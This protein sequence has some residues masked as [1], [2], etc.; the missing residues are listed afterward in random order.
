M[1]LATVVPQGII[2][3]AL[4]ALFVFG[5]IHGRRHGQEIADRQVLRDPS[6]TR[7]TWA[8]DTAVRSTLGV[9]LGSALILLSAIQLITRQCLYIFCIGEARSVGNGAI[10]YAIFGILG[11]LTLLSVVKAWPSVLSALRRKGSR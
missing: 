4:G 2:G 10:A 3:L 7:E 6:W 9:I 8:R 5:G 11:L 1:A